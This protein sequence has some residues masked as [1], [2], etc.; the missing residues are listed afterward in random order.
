MFKLIKKKTKIILENAENFKITVI[1]FSYFFKYEQIGQFK[2]FGTMTVLGLSIC[3]IGI[4]REKLPT[5]N[6]IL[7]YHFI[8]KNNFNVFCF[9][10]L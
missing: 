9:S 4:Y 3:N 10:Y 2:S 5:E 8:T 6:L 1:K 7:A